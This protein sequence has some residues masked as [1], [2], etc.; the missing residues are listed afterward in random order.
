MKLK[1]LNFISLNPQLIESY[2]RFGP[3]R[4]AKEQKLIEFQNINLRN[5]AYDSRG[6]VDDKPYGG[7]DS[8]VM[9]ADCLA[10]AIQGIGA[11]TFVVAASP[12]GK[13]WS[14]SYANELPLQHESITFLCPR[15]AGLDQ[16]FI[17][18]YVDLEVSL[19]DFVVSGG[20]LPSLI[21]ADSILRMIPGVLG[22]AE[23]A[24]RDSF[25]DPN[26]PRLEEDLYT[27]PEVFEG[28][29]VPPVLLSGDHK[30]IEEWREKN[31]ALKT[32]EMLTKR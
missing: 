31:S 24:L 28:V 4:S 6:S 13:R 1:S 2:M 20:E 17:D 12:R 10:M 21:M 29:S 22:N 16:R 5:Y 27:R 11:R 30:K 18:R 7:G 26:H 19:G 9:R 3:L 32:Q 15:F 25:S 14:Q 23:S 8:M